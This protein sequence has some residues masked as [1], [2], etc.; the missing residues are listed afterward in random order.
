MASMAFILGGFTTQALAAQIGFDLEGEFPA[1]TGN[2]TISGMFTFDTDVNQISSFMFT[3]TSTFFADQTGNLDPF[4]LQYSLPD[5][6]IRLNNVDGLV[7]LQFHPLSFPDL[8]IVESTLSILVTDNPFPNTT[9]A[10]V[11][12][13]V[14]GRLLNGEFFTLTQQ[15]TATIS[16]K[17]INP[18]PVPAPGTM[19][20]MSS[21]LLGLAGYRWKQRR[22]G[23]AHIKEPLA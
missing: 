11:A 13:S 16:R 19:L 7:L 8:P 20:L 2:T 17:D 9:R 6:G 10:R 23:Q 18:E 5:S 14:N 15:G 4:P 3:T 21:G 12:E 22:G 1:E